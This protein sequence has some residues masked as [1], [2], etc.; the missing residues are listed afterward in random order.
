MAYPIQE[1]KN[2][3]NFVE[4]LIIINSWGNGH[5]LGV[6]SIIVC[7]VLIGVMTG[8]GVR[9]E[10]AL[11]ATSFV[12]FIISMLLWA[13]RFEGLT[14]LPTFYPFVFGLMLGVGCFMLIMDKVLNE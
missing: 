8:A 6:F 4:W 11:V 2:G 9:F 13:A 12:S 3:S 5:P 14:L 1:L 7:L 10:K